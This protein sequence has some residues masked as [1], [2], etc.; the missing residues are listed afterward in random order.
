MK[1]VIYDDLKPENERSPDLDHNKGKSVI[2]RGYVR[3]DLYGCGEYER[4]DKYGSPV[5]HQDNRTMP[6]EFVPDHRRE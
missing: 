5:T 4:K 2:E 1:A 3:D 6:G